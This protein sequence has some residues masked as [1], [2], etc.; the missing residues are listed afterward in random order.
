MLYLGENIYIL[1]MK[2]YI[3]VYNMGGWKSSRA[4]SG[5]VPLAG[6]VLTQGRQASPKAGRRLTQLCHCHTPVRRPDHQ[7]MAY[8]CKSVS[9]VKILARAPLGVLAVIRPIRTL[10]DNIH[11]MVLVLVRHSYIWVLLSVESL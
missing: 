10:T 9:L 2:R 7:Y 11:G 5:P 3:Y 1:E 4:V 8:N 6:H